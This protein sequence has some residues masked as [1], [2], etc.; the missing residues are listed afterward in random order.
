MWSEGVCSKC[1]A[2]IGRD[3]DHRLRVLEYPP[4]FIHEIGV[5][6]SESEAEDR[7]K[8]D[9]PDYYQGNSGTEDASEAASHD[10]QASISGE[11]SVKGGQRE[12]GHCNHCHA[13]IILSNAKFCS[14][15]GSSLRH[16]T[17]DVT[18]Y[19]GAAKT[20]TQLPSARVENAEKC[21]VCDLELTSGDDVVWCPHCGN[22]AH[23]RHLLE[24][25]HVRGCCPVCGTA[26]QERDF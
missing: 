20:K 3:A 7:W 14:N 9:H 25:V 10:K 5:D 11:P 13:V 16:G 1:G 8:R 23:R 2:S 22:P 12:W 4:G 17:R 19:E 26:L 24:W 15:C 6:L 18:P 21:M